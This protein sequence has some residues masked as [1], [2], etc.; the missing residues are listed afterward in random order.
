MVE[1]VLGD[2]GVRH[3]EDILQTGGGIPMLGQGKLTAR[4]AQAID[5]LDGDHI[6]RRNRLRALRHMTGDD[7][8]E[9][10][11]LPQ[12]MRQP[13]I[14]EAPAVAPADLV[15]TDAKHARIVG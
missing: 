14:P 2:Q 4:L 11:E 6:G 10:Q 5:H 9:L 15:Q 1:A 8:V 3:A 13:D 12:P 7:L